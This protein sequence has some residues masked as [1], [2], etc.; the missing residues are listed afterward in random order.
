MGVLV[1]TRRQNERVRI[2]LEDGRTI[3]IQLRD[4]RGAGAARPCARLAILAPETIRVLR[5][6]VC[7][8]E[9]RWDAIKGGTDE[10][11]QMV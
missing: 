6:E 3:W 2:D 8:P 7:E 11:T 4:I 9:E 10:E 5:E 1:I